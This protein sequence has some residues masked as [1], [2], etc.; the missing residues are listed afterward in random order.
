M[1]LQGEFFLAV[2]MLQ[3]NN[4]LRWELVV[5][6]RLV[7]YARSRNF[8]RELYIKISNATCLVVIGGAFNLVRCAEDKSN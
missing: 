7:D 6:Y 2:D 3:L 5:V 4:S 1:V 8:L